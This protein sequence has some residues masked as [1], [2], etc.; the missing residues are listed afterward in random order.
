MRK[1]AYQTRVELCTFGPVCKTQYPELCYQRQ[2]RIWRILDVSWGSE[3][4]VGSQY[5]TRASLLADL[6]RYAKA[7][8][9]Y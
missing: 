2:G 1:S 8:G 7:F 3:S 6:E 5:P 9:C 4:P